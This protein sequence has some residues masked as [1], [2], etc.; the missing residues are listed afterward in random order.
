[1]KK[2]DTTSLTVATESVLINSTID[3][4]DIQKLA[5]VDIP[6]DFM[7]TPMDPKEPKFHM[8]L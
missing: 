6:S 2:E 5:T 4:F 7:H 1:M 8:A 3:A